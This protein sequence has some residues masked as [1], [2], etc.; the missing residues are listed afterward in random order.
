MKVMNNQGT[1]VAIE[2]T[3]SISGTQSLNSQVRIKKEGSSSN[4]RI[5]NIANVR[6]NKVVVQLEGEDTYKTYTFEQLQNLT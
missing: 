1:L 3:V 2:D 4:G 5:A 6:N